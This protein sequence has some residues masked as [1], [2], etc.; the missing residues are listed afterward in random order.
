[1]CKG[2]P[3]YTPHLIIASGEFIFPIPHK[4]GNDTDSIFANTGISE[5]LTIAK[6]ILKDEF[7]SKNIGQIYKDINNEYELSVND[8]SARVLL[9]DTTAIDKKLTCLRILLQRFGG[10]EELV[11]YEILDLKY[12]N[13]IVCTKK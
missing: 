10:T 9:G 2:S 11:P 8:L 5:S 3:N 6:A 4:H 13:Q 1:M 7:L 12:N